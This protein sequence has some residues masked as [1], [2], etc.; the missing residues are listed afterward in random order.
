[1]QNA[2]SRPN[3]LLA[4]L[5]LLILCI[6]SQASILN[7][8]FMIDDSFFQ[9]DQETFK[10]YPHFLDFFTQNPSTHYI[11]FNFLVNVSL[12]HL[13]KH[14]FP[15]YLLNIV[16]FYVNCLLLFIFVR[17]ISKNTAAALLT[18]FIFCVHPMSAEIVEHITF[19]IILI[20]LALLEIGLI[21]L[22]KYFQSKEQHIF[23]YIASLAAFSCALLCQE[24]SLLFPLYAAALLFFMTDAS[25]AKIIRT[26]IPYIL[27]D[28]LLV[29]LWLVNAGH[30]ANLIQSIQTFQLTLWG[31]STNFFGLIAWYLKNLIVPQNIVFEYSLTPAGNPSILWNIISCGTLTGYLLLVFCYFKKSIESFAL[32]LFLTGFIYAAPASL[33][34]PDIGMVFEPHWLY[35]PSIGFI[36]F[37]VL[38]LMKLKGRI[39]R[40]LYVALVTAILMSLLVDTGFLHV[41]GR[42]EVKYCENWLRASPHNSYAMFLLARHYSSDKNLSVPCDLVPDMINA[43]DIL[44]KNNLY[45]SA[46]RLIEKL[47]GY[48]LS[49]LQ[50]KE[51]L[52]KSK[53]TYLLAGVNLA[54]QGLYEKSIAVW[55][56]GLAIDPT[57]GRFLADIKKA[58]ELESQ[59]DLTAEEQKKDQSHP[60]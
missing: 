43:V 60:F 34:H 49:P 18:S 44:I 27:L 37:M 39:H 42:N 16:L 28:L 47:S 25:P 10:L 59:F 36:L 52:L 11:P 4:P 15:L 30:T 8:S 12:F 38:M 7:H 26:V 17:L 6:V 53:E 20:Q 46:P 21:T 24:N 29:T 58:K 33:A 14:P 48:T 55:E 56:K 22:Y 13:I 2:S 51:L 9:N 50:R 31:W 41:K 57:D 45:I 35:F 1:M 40:L 32:I 23:Y 5:L 19:N 54:D 3:P